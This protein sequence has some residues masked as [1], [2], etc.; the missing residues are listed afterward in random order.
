MELVKN[1]EK[2]EQLNKALNDESTLR[3]YEKEFENYKVAWLPKVLGLFLVYAGNMVYG[4]KPSLLKF[5][6]VEVIARIPYHS[7]V[8]ASFTLMTLFF[9]NE[10]KALIYSSVAEFSH[11]AEENETM[12]VVVISYLA[13]QEGEVGFF[14]FTFIPMMFSFF[15]FWM[16][17]V[18]YLM[19][20]KYSYEL[21][22]M[23]ENHAFDQY[24]KFLKQN[25]NDLKTKRV[26]SKFLQWYG[27]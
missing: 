4:K 3:I 21:N 13:K 12:H 10:K 9:S 15:Y 14:K 27:D 2:L 6:S 8:S 20:P 1:N 23:F 16:S 5:R 24:S 17:Y 11:F 25:E 18:L 26:E 19:N 7:W 22:Y